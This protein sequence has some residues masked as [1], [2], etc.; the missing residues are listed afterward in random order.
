MAVKHTIAWVDIPVIDL[1]RVVAF[2]ETVLG[3]SVQKRAEHGFEF[4]LLPHC[5][6]HTSCERKSF[7]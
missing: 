2:Y 4:G 6:F 3:V 1:D 7:Q 5:D